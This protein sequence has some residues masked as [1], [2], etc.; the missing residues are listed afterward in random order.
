MGWGGDPAD[1]DNQ[2][3]AAG[4]SFARLGRMNALG[5]WSLKENL[6]DFEATANPTGDEVDSNP[7]G[8]LSLPGKLVVADAGANDLLEVSPKG[9]VSVLA[10]FPNRLGAMP[11]GYEFIPDLPP[12]GTLLDMDTVPTSVA[13]GP[14][15]NY[16]VGQLTGFPF[17]IN[18]ANVYSVPADGGSA[19]IHAG[20]FTAIVDIAFGPDGSMY[21][22]EIAKNGLLAGFILG[23]WTG[24]VIRVAPN[25]ARTE[26]ASAG[27]FAP[28]GLAIGNDGALY[29]TNNSIFSGTGEV[30]RIVP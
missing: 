26:I 27:L 1:R 8:L 29:V 14:D 11:P 10:T 28:G 18:D 30:L 7:Y 9:N 6:G 25:G 12:P 5:K 17:P 4:A 23:D 21:V 24:A 2:F 3:G 13:L 22:L 19:Q 20:G 15:G 16:Y